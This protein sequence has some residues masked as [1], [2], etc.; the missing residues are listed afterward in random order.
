[1]GNS[2]D[3]VVSRSPGKG[4]LTVSVTGKKCELMCSHCSAKHLAGMMSVSSPDELLKIA[5]EAFHFGTKGILISGGSD[6]NGKVPLR[7]Y[8][9]TV[10]KI[11]NL[12]L[13]V[14]IHPGLLTE[15]DLPLFSNLEKLYLSIDVH[16][17]PEVI[18]K[19]FHLS[20][21]SDY[22][23]ALDVALST[24]CKV[25]PHLTVGLSEKDFIKSAKLV[26]ERGIRDIVLLGLVP[27]EGTEFEHCNTTEDEIVEAVKTL[28]GM[29]FNVAL[30]C[31]RDRRMR[32][33]ERRCI[34]A[35]IRKIANL[36]QET[37]LWA[38]AEGYEVLRENLCCCFSE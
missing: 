1:M 29:D 12:G 38:K 33:L 35:G 3:T 19:I 32:N 13:K 21:S 5:E 18:R 9:P 7:H 30:G 27:T 34:E 17:D 14:N 6:K 2:K 28:V 10:E 11:L 15:E 20:D 8:I 22:V 36:S 23:K 16:Q 25:V 26:K 37:E 4:F 24:K 31:M